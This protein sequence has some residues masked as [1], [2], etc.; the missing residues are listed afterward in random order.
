MSIQSEIER[1]NIAK[2]KLR[3]WLESRGYSVPENASLN[4]LVDMLP[5]EGWI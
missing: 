5:T 1:I 4:D 2:L 3:Y